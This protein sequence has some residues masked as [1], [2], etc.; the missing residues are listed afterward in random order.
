MKGD[1][2]TRKKTAASQHPDGKGLWQHAAQVL[3]PHL[4]YPFLTLQRTIVLE[5]PQHIYLAIAEFVQIILQVLIYRPEIMLL[6]QKSSRAEGHVG[7][8][9]TLTT[10][11]SIPDIFFFQSLEE[12]IKLPQNWKT[13]VRKPHR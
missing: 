3:P 8:C 4:S 12:N 1:N 13:D 9:E 2:F 11:C 5:K 10:A 6:I 7:L